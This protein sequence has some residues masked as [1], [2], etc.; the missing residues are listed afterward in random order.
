VSGRRAPRDWWPGRYFGRRLTRLAPLPRPA[1]PLYTLGTAARIERIRLIY[2]RSDFP[3]YPERVVASPC[4]A[5]RHGTGQ[6]T[7]AA[8][9]R[10]FTH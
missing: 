5:T 7:D 2:L 10:W 4:G 8:T 1:P 3:G 6:L 9:A